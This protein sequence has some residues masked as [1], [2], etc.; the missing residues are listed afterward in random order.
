MKTYSETK[1]RAPFDWNKFLS[2]ALKDGVTER[3][4]ERAADRAVSWVT[5]AC[6]N[7]C[8]LIERA[9]DGRPCDLKLNRLGMCFYGEVENH[10]WHDAKVLLRKIEKRSA[11]LIAEFFK[12][13]GIK[14]SCL[15]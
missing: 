7:T 3:Q 15:K 14:K 1:G 13:H 5:C 2:K 8:S 6:G 10:H 11:F 4:A 12:T 9:R